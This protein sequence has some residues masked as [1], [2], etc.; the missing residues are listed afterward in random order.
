MTDITTHIIGRGQSATLDNQ[1]DRSAQFLESDQA[2]RAAAIKFEATFLAE[3][4]KHTGL[5]EMPDGFNGGHGEAGF[6]DFLVHEYAESIAS[7]RSTGLADQI[8]QALKERSQK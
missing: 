1:V 6:S 3:M 8:Y 7:T 2:M 5:G 4:L